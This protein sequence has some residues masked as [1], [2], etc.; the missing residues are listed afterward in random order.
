LREPASVGVPSES[1]A[2]TTSVLSLF[3]PGGAQATAGVLH[4]AMAISPEKLSSVAS[5][6]PPL[7]S[8]RF[9]SAMVASRPFPTSDEPA[10]M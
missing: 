6:P 9:C 3:V 2:R 4:R 10:L 5:S 8:T 7:T 1:L